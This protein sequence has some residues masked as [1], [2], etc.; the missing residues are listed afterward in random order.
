MLTDSYRRPPVRFPQTPS[1][2]HNVTVL[3]RFLALAA[4]LL[5]A[6]ASADVH[7]YA[8]PLQPESALLDF[9]APAAESAPSENP[10]A[11]PSRAREFCPAPQKRTSSWGVRYYQLDA[12]ETPVALADADGNTSSRTRFSPWGVTKEQ[13][14]D[15]ATSSTDTTGTGQAPLLSNDD[16]SIGF[17]GYV[18]DE[19]TGLYYAGAR[20][21][22][23]LIG[24]FDSMDPVR[25]NPNRPLS[26]NPYLYGNSNPTTYVDDGGRSA[27]VAFT[28]GGFVWGTGQAIGGAYWDYLDT[29]K[30]PTWGEFTSVIGQNTIG[31]AELGLSIDALALSGGLAAPVSGALG[32]AGFNAVTFGGHAET[33][34]DF[35]HEQLVGAGLGAA[36]GP[37][38]SRVAPFLGGVAGNVLSRIPGAPE[39]G[40]AIAS[41]AQ[42]FA[43]NI[44]ERYQPTVAERTLIS[45][46]DD[47]A[48]QATQRV[49]NTLQGPWRATE[50][51]IGEPKFVPEGAK[52]LSE[53]FEDPKAGHEVAKEVLPGGSRRAIAGHGSR[54]YPRTDMVIPDGTAVTALREGVKV[55]D[56]IGRM[57]E[58]NDWE[59]IYN[60]L[61]DESSDEA[62]RRSMQVQGLSTYLPGAKMPNYTVAPPGPELPLTILENSVTVGKPTRLSNLIQEDQGCIVLATCTF[63]SDEWFE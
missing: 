14:A 56:D 32:G 5:L 24:G 2:Y 62:V 52:P 50:G 59:A 7:A 53:Y 9:F 17:T 40:Q 51:E 3:S 45:S 19:A 25:G 20:F 37:I 27:T 18:K 57:L 22:D 6:C 23:P 47:V 16:Q 15:G 38:V 26:F 34:S 43:K 58:R 21:Y 60:V 46:I 63:P 35:G 44:A 36:L 1:R 41:G 28:V 30:T 8:R 11:T 49:K 54:D 39:L 55:D 42:R 10:R 31:G 12:L 4:V 33:W 61:I 13:T 29:R 48:K